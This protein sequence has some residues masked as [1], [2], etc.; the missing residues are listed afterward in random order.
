MINVIK[1]MINTIIPRTIINM[2]KV[3]QTACSCNLLDSEFHNVAGAA[4]G[5]RIYFFCNLCKIGKNVN[6]ILEMILQKITF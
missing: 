3:M 1:K 5:A 6:A 2:R 4:V